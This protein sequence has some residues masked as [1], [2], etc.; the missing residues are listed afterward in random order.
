MKGAFAAQTASFSFPFWERLM[1]PQIST[2]AAMTAVT[3]KLTRL[4]TD[5]AKM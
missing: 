5:A 2:A 4:M 3:A 1:P